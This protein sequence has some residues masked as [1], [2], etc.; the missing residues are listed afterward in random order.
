MEKMKL[1]SPDMTAENVIKIET[2]FPNCVT[3][4]KDENGKPKKAVNFKLLKQ[5]LSSHF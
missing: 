5:M 4:T 3:E 1:E 2:L